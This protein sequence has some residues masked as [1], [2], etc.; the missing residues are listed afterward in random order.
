[1]LIMAMLSTSPVGHSKVLTRNFELKDAIQEF[2]TAKGKPV[3]EFDDPT[4]L[5]DSAFLTD[6][7]SHLNELNLKLQSKDQLV[8]ALFKHR[9][10]R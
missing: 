1:M 3:S 4:W 9:L 6:I 2:M 7:S 5:A 10:F 8:H